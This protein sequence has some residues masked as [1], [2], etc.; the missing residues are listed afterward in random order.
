[1]NKYFLLLLV[2]IFAMAFITCDLQPTLTI[3]NNSGVVL[4]NVKWNG[5][6][7]A[8]VNESYEDNY[9][10]LADKRSHEVDSGSGYIF[11]NIVTGKNGYNNNIYKQGRT[12]ELIELG[13]N[14]NKVFTFSDSTIVIG[15]NLNSTPMT[16]QEF[17]YK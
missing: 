7:F 10:K 11:F 16:L 17:A 9:I 4:Y 12:Q 1:M 6:K 15:T 8:N 3:S 14:E 5:T 13:K 2:I